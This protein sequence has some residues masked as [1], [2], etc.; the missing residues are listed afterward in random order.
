DAREQATAAGV[1][2]VATTVHDDESVTG[3]IRS[4]ATEVDADCIV[5]GTHGRTG[6]DR[7]LLGSVA[8]TLI[9]TSPIPVMVVPPVDQTDTE[10]PV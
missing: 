9:R 5:V 10:R 3:G 1:E 4:C 8:E 2:D 7:Y 6:L